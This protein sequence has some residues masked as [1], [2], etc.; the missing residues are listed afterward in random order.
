MSNK[1][2][3]KIICLNLRIY[4]RKIVTKS[5]VSVCWNI[6]AYKLKYD[7]YIFFLIRIYYIYK[8]IVHPSNESDSF[9]E[10]ELFRHL[11]S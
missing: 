10:L 3:L 4:Q 8:F 9:V 6:F 2:R 5:L 7:V 1:D 11:P